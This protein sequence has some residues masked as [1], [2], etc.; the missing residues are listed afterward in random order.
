MLPL[1]QQP[2]SFHCLEQSYPKY[3]WSNVP[4]LTT[5]SSH[6]KMLHIMWLHFQTLK[7]LVRTL[8]TQKAH[9]IKDKTLKHC[10]SEEASPNERSIV[11]SEPIKV[12]SEKLIPFWPGQKDLSKIQSLQ[13]HLMDE[14]YSVCSDSHP[15]WPA[16]KQI[17][18]SIQFINKKFYHVME[19]KAHPWNKTKGHP[20]TRHMSEL[21]AGVGV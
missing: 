2:Q 20:L 21:C 17:F 13:S 6:S 7:T 19:Q 9:F 3:I 18:S 8:H 15:E 5:Q 12:I 11:S 16:G 10:I 14:H 4:C 1:V